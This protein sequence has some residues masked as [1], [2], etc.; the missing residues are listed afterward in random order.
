MKIL[1]NI[2]YI[3][4]ASGCITVKA[5]STSDVFFKAMNDEIT[6]STTDLHLENSKPPFFVSYTICDSKLVFVSS[7]LGS[8]TTYSEY[9]L[10]TCG[11]RLMQG[12]YDLND[13]NFVGTRSYSG[14][15]SLPMPIEDN[16]SAVRR[17][18]W[19]MTD[20]TYKSS[21][22]SYQQKLSALKQQNNQ[23]ADRLPDFTKIEPLTKIINNPV[24]PFN[25]ASLEKKAKELSACFKDYPEVITSNV[26]IYAIQSDFYRLSNEGTKLKLPNNLALL[27]INAAIQAQDGEVLTNQLHYLAFTTEELPS[28]ESIIQDIKKMAGSLMA[29][30]SAPVMKESYNGPIIFEGEAAAI[31][32]DQLLFSSNGLISTREKVVSSDRQGG[33]SENNLDNRTGQR[34]VSPSISVYATPKLKN[35]DNKPLLGS[36]EIDAEGVIPADELKLI[37][38]GFLKTL[39]NDR[40]PTVSAKESNGH[41]RM[42]LGSAGGAKAPGVIKITDDAAESVKNI[43]KQVKKEAISNHQDYYYVIRKLALATPGMS[44]VISKS[45]NVNSPAPKPLEIYRVSVKTG[46]E[47]LVRSALI[48]EISMSNLKELI[49]TSKDMQV[50]N[51][52]DAGNKF[53]ISYIMPEMMAFKDLTLVINKQQKPQIPV[54]ASPLK[55]SN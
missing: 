54:V 17:A 31:I 45:L 9:P 28:T 32:M 6:R 48:N 11:L 33:G 25:Q 38:K 36:Y 10:R 52:P 30:K 49:G 14:G 3:V 21:V 50:F 20:R 5:Q 8:I 2:I 34:I 37:D 43:C 35:Y 12:S 19:T 27:S 29:M 15:I 4:L 44:T 1:R 13:E 23:N 16:Y 41:Y 22:E 7:T 46:Q 26:S 51:L 40:V 47:E 55:N 42:F 53:V 39:L 24:S 18:L